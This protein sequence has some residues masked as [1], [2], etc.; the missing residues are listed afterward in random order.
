MAGKS[1]K[2]CEKLTPVPGSGYIAGYFTRLFGLLYPPLNLK[3]MVFVFAAVIAFFTFLFWNIARFNRSSARHK[4]CK[5]GDS[6]N[7]RIA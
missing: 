4:G 1:F 3:R 6:K 2:K 7:G 5:L